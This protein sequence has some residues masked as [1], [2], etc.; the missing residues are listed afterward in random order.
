MACLLFIYKFYFLVEFYLV[1]VLDFLIVLSCPLEE[2][3][4]II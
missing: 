2:L 3:M 4:N 1:I